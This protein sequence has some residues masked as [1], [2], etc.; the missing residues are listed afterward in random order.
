MQPPRSSICYQYSDSFHTQTLCG[1][2]SLLKVSLAKRHVLLQLLR[3]RVQSWNDGNCRQRLQTDDV[4][5]FN[6]EGIFRDLALQDYETRRR[7]GPRFSRRRT[8]SCG[9]DRNSPSDTG[10][11]EASTGEKLNTKRSFVFAAL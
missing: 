11:E 9:N 5:E 10:T 7:T 8:K 1:Q 6:V 4:P 3:L 2:F